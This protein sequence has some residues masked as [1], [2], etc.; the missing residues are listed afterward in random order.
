MTESLLY[1]WNLVEP[2]RRREQP[3]RL[4]DETL[5]DGIQSP[6]VRNP[7][8]EDKLELLH[9]MDRCGIEDVDVGLP[10]AGEQAVADVTRLVQEIKDAGL[11]IRPNC[12]ARTH[13]H[14]VGA[15]ID[16]SQKTGYPVEVCTFIG[17]SPV[18]QLVE[19]WDLD[20]M[21]GLVARAVD[22]AVRGNL[23]AT[24]V[25]EDTIRSDPR[26]LD[27]LFRTAIDHGATRLVLTDTVGHATPDGLINLVRFTRSLLR[28]MGAQ[29]VQLDWHGHNDRG[30]SL[31]LCLTAIEEGVERIH[32]CCLGIGE[33]VGNA[34]IDL[35]LVNL[36]LLGWME[37]DLRPLV[38]YVEKVSRSYG[39]PVPNNYPVF[40]SDAF[41]TATGVHAAA[42]AKALRSGRR[43]LADRVYSSVPAGEFG[44]R[45]R[46]EIGYYSG[47]ANVTFWLE[48]HGLAA[49]EERISALWD[50]AKSSAKTLSEDEIEGCLRA[51]GLLESSAIVEAS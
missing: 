24:F 44:R 29:H 48:E 27:R 7:A 2:R 45:Q 30:L 26:H 46:V 22:L 35:L 33:R 12:A 10:G 5:R 37:R 50:L 8:I 23:P 42:I 16:I 28:S 43:D 36:K 4:L 19:G 25:T 20:R 18:R 3:F 13:E 38:Q 40:G 39:V 34:S 1:D 47:R 6:S 32:G 9:L 11:A 51:R 14:D 15:V 49:T 41:R 31:S 17:C 21:E